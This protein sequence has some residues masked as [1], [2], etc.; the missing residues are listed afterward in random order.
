MET[1]QGFSAK[2]SESKTERVE[3][4]FAR[5][6]TAANNYERLNRNRGDLYQQIYQHRESST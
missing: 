2:I 3:V 5:K 1:V 4:D 6:R